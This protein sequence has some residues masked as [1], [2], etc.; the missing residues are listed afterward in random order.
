MR[1]TTDVGG[2]AAGPIDQT[3]HE[4]AY[5]EKR[6]D[7]LM[8]ILAR[9]QRITVDEIRFSIERLGEKAYTEMSYYERWIDA[10]TNALI[11]RGVLSVEEVS[12]RIG[13]VE[14]RG[15]E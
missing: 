7:A 9:E 4:K 12:M 3:P 5:W 11:A 2:L 10:M 6:V 14:A 1:S 15:H 8:M 13:E